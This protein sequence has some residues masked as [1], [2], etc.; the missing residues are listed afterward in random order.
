MSIEAPEWL[1]A[2][3]PEADLVVSTRVRLARNL[4]GHRFWGRN[5]TDEREAILAAVQGAVT[6]IPQLS[7]GRWHRMDRLAPGSRRWLH[8]RQLVSREHAALDQVD[9]PRSA[10]ALLVAGPKAIMVNEEDHLRIQA[11]TSGFD[12]GRAGAAAAAVNRDLGERISFAFDP[13]FGYLTGCPTNVGTGLRAS[14]LIH[15]P[16]LVATGEI[17]KVLQGIGQMGLTHRGLWGEGSQAEGHLFQLS[18]QTTLGRSESDLMD[19][20]GR[21]VHEVILHERRARMVVRGVP[22]IEDRVGRAWGV[23]RHAR[24][25]QVGEMVDLLGSVRLGVGLDV[26]PAVP[27]HTL[28]R[29][30]VL[31]Q[32]AHLAR[33]GGQGSEADDLPVRRAR[34]VHQLLDERDLA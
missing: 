15:L 1:D 33:S 27:M 22:T 13:D 16:A 12:L 30:L 3:G 29:L 25:L 10:A 5:G 6:A 8:E 34:I 23:L 17:G 18:N 31:G 11:M 20:L 26:L 32:D 2:S 9:H 24:M 28:N 14:V 7:G 19:H 4:A 21:V